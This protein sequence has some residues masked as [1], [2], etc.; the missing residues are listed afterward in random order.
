MNAKDLFDEL[1][2]YCQANADVKV[3]EKYSR[4]FKEGFDAYGLTSELMTKKADEVV[5]R[6]GMNLNL[7]L[8]VAP[9]LIKTGK[10][11]E[12]SF[13]YLF[14]K[15]FEKDFTRETFDAIEKWF[16]VGII[17]WG[18]TDVICSDLIPYFLEK[19]LVTINDFDTWKVADNK[20]QRRAVPVS[21]IKPMKKGLDIPMLLDYIDSMMLDKERVVHQGLGWFIR[22]CWKK[23]PEVVETFLHKWKATAPRLIFQYA[24]EK[25]SKEYRVQFRKPKG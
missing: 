17:N 10:Y 12:T 15:A 25:M 4:Y 22:E 1:R 19:Q 18:H 5:S 21:L 20:F 11:E 3:V 2:A 8:E 24:T 13:A 23:Q 14:C 6:E 7:V 9:L 16:S